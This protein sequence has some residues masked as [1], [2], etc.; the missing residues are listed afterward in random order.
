MPKILV[1]GDVGGNLEELYKRVSA[2]NAKSGPFDC[3]FCTGEFFGSADVGGERLPDSEKCTSQGP[4]LLARSRLAACSRAQCTMLLSS[5]ALWVAPLSVLLLAERWAQTRLDGDLARDGGAC[6]SART[7]AGPPLIHALTPCARP[8]M[9]GAALRT[10]ACVLRADDWT[11]RAARRR[12]RAAKLRGPRS[13]STLQEGR[14][15]SPT[16]DIFHLRQGGVCFIVD[17]RTGICALEHF[18]V[19]QCVRV[20]C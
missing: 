12:R 14:K 16:A 6:D 2:V 7:P 17:I 1:T 4:H 15:D 9:H 8:P 19:R 3:L 13:D 5:S 11:P 18:A 20:R 10:L